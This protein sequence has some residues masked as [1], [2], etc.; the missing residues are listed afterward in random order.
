MVVVCPQYGST[1]SPSCV[2]GGA[3]V[4]DRDCCICGKRQVEAN[5]RC[6]RCRNYLSQ[7]GWDRPIDVVSI[8]NQPQPARPTPNGIKGEM[9]KSID[10][11]RDGGTMTYESWCRANGY[12]RTKREYVGA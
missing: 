10:G 6:H 5:G 11:E 8:A 1:R 2:F 4:K 7:Y 3:V 12:D 9:A